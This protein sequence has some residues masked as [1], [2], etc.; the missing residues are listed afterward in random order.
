[1][2]I[3][4]CWLIL[5]KTQKRLQNVPLIPK[6]FAKNPKS[7][8]ATKLPVLIPPPDIIL[9]YHLK[10]LIWVLKLLFSVRN[11]QDAAGAFQ[12]HSWRFA[13][14]STGFCSS[15]CHRILPSPHHKPFKNCLKTSREV[16]WNIWK[17]YLHCIP[18]LTQKNP[19]A[20]SGS[21]SQ[22]FQNHILA[23]REV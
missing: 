5:W 23:P 1:M 8:P 17:V 14:G 2:H 11:Y 22:G 16:I 6:V 7:R 12:G 21:S 3:L 18:H 13:R 20:G 19:V 9:N 10:L 4:Q 15:N